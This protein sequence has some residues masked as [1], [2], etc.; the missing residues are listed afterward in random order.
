[1]LRS[2]FH[3]NPLRCFCKDDWVLCYSDGRDQDGACVKV[4]SLLSC[5]EQ[6]RPP[7]GLTGCKP[8]T[9]G[10]YMLSFTA[11]GVGLRTQICLAVGV[12]LRKLAKPIPKISKNRWL[13][14]KNEVNPSVFSVGIGRQVSVS[15]LSFDRRS[16][17]GPKTLNRGPGSGSAPRPVLPL[18]PPPPV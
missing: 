14:V 15:V 5:A 7:S 18:R 13:S 6:I 8:E 3:E 4:C 1:M 11:V 2:P 12:T 10:L 17:F 16:Q 9:V